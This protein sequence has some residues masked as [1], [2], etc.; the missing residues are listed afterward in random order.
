MASLV[1]RAG[2]SLAIKALPA[3]YGAGLVLLVVRMVPLGDF[4][5][6]GMAIAY[7]N[8]VSV[9]C[10]GLWSS[11]LTIHAAR[12]QRDTYLAPAF[13]FSLGTNAIGGALGLII[14]PLLGVGFDLALMSGIM[15]LILVPRDLSAALAQA[16]NRVW[17]AFLIEA[18]YS[19]GCLGGFVLLAA[20]GELRT[21]EAA[22]IV[23]VAGA[24]LSTLIGI[25]FE[26]GLLR[27]GTHGDWKEA[28]RFGRWIGLLALGEIFLQQGDAL[29]I[30]AFF[31]PEVIAPYL[32]ARTLLRMYTLL[33]QAVN[34]LVLPSASR[35][36][37]SGQIRLLRR[38]LKMVLLSL[39]G[40]LLPVNV[41]MWFLCPMIFPAVMGAKYIP[42][43]PF[44]RLLIIVTF[45]EPVYSVLNNAMA[46][47]G[48]SQKMVI[49]LGTGLAFNVTMNLILLPLVGLWAAPAVL[50]ATYAILAFGSVRMSRR[51]LV[52]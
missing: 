48:K 15:L 13:W 52:A 46:G 27:P 49:L 42:A 35:L 28:F 34:F 17:V 26:P 36:A 32:A 2:A 8:V 25:A 43:I 7:I 38:R 20:L 18:G 31:N 16:A 33:S 5:R 29:L 41:A 19:V 50:L 51:H 1:H 39:D 3:I 30:G 47:V 44:F 23:N 37:P 22:M 9:L 4:G 11:S 21:A 6:Y 40:M 45:L 10:R 14:L 12:G 24:V